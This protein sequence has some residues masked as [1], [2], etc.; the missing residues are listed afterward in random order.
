MSATDISST[1]AKRLKEKA[2][3]DCPLSRDEVENKNDERHH[4]KEVYEGTT[5]FG[6]QSHQPQHPQYC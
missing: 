3:L 6:Q 5:D 1:G 2:C 4:E